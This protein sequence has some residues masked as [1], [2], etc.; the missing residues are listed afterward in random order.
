MRIRNVIISPSDPSPHRKLW[1]IAEKKCW[2]AVFRVIISYQKYYYL[3]S[4]NIPP[5]QQYVPEE[6]RPEMEK[7]CSLGTLDPVGQWMHFLLQFLT[8][9]AIK[10]DIL[11][12]WE[13]K[14]TGLDWTRLDAN[15]QFYTL[16]QLYC[17]VFSLCRSH[18]DGNKTISHKDLNMQSIIIAVISCYYVKWPSYKSGS[19]RF[20]S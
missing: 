17:L 11:H 2:I 4:E 12:E 3:I 13:L 14:L 8:P 5:W 10:I 1:K 16:A 7:R 9:F 20:F 18:G 19:K 15:A 6:R